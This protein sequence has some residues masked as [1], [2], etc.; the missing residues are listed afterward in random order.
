L[1]EFGVV[2][3]CVFFEYGYVVLWHE[4]VLVFVVRRGGVDDGEVFA[5]RVVV[6]EYVSL[7]VVF[8]VY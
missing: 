1:F 4:V 2:E 8:D 5:W 3:D 6:G 7:F